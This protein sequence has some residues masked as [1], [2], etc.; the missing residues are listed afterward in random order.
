MTLARRVQCDAGTIGRLALP[1]RTL[2]TLELP[3]RDNRRG[4][5][6]IRVGVYRCVAWLSPTK[7]WVYRLLDVPGRGNVLIHAGNYAGDAAKGFRT[8]SQGCILVGLWLGFLDGQLAVLRSRP[9]LVEIMAIL[10]RQPFDLE[11]RGA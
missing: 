5:S 3:W 10:D 7:G 9:A 6:C 4:A 11:V 8:H 2:W 1:G